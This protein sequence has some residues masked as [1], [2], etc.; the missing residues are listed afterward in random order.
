MNEADNI[1]NRLVPMS[2]PTDVKRL[3]DS[4][5]DVDLLFVGGPILKFK[6]DLVEF[7]RS[8]SIP[9]K[10]VATVRSDLYPYGDTPEGEI[11][12][13]SRQYGVNSFGNSGIHTF[14]GDELDPN[15]G[16]I[17]VS[18][19][20]RYGRQFKEVC[21]VLERHLNRN[22]NPGSNPPTYAFFKKTRDDAGYVLNNNVF[23]PV[24]KQF[25]GDYLPFRPAF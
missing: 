4:G 17:M 5:L 8:L 16:L 6:D 22:L 20:I 12:P 19:S 24:S 23:V 15:N 25:G 18:T 13:G 10:N 1:E 11:T 7:L 9:I 3:F 14:K 2:Q 21:E